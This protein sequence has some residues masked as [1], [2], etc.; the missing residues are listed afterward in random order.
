MGRVLRGGFLEKLRLTQVFKEG[1][2]WLGGVGR[3]HS[4]AGAW[5][6]EPE[7]VSTWE[8]EGR[9]RSPEL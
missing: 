9:V 1:R 6:W 3:G 2:A 8:V 4:Q 7:E 5:L